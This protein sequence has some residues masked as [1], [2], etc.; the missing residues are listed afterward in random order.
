[1]IADKSTNSQR[2]PGVWECTLSELKTGMKDTVIS[3]NPETISSA[4]G[5]AVV[6]DGISDGFF[7]KDNP[8]YNLT[9]FTVEI[10]IRPDAGGPVEQR[11]LHIGDID[12]DRLL[13]ETRTVDNDKWYLDTF[14]LSGEFKLA[15]IDTKLLHNTGSWYHMALTLDKNG[16]MTNYINGKM[17]INGHLNYNPI[18]SGEMSIGV[19][20]NKISWYKGAIYKIRITPEVLAPKDFFPY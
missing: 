3:G 5:D 13:I 14:I 4:Y 20:R 17:E 2:H 7:L 10:L 11:F 1:M 19:R 6:F 9:G 8:L 16:Q 18:N 12:G 15:L